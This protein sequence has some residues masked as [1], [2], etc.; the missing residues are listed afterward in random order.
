MVFCDFDFFFWRFHWNSS[1]FSTAILT[2][3]I[4]FSDF[5]TFL[6]YKE[7]KVNIQQMMSSFFHSK[8]VLQQLC[9]PSLIMVKQKNW[10]KSKLHKRN[11]NVSVYS[12]I[13]GHIY[14]INDTHRERLMFHS[15]QYRNGWL[16]SSDL[17]DMFTQLIKFYTFH[18]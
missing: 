1:R 12:K 5:L 2:I 16:A 8:W 11:A 4:I 10:K 14:L 18:Y 15:V 17:F 7:T 6:S 3:F 13:K 9:K